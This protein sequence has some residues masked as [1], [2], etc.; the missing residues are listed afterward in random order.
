MSQPTVQRFRGKVLQSDGPRSWRPA[1]WPSAFP[2]LALLLTS[3]VGTALNIPLHWAV[4]DASGA[5]GVLELVGPEDWKARG[6][7]WQCCTAFS[8]GIFQ[9]AQ[10]AGLLRLLA[11]ISIS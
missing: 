9:Q 7:G 8:A 11:G 6:P 10:N 2:P 1:W 3:A 5:Y 4:S